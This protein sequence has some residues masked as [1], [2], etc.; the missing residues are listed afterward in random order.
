MPG[1]FKLTDMYR[2]INNME[3][4]SLNKITE[5]CL[6]LDIRTQMQSLRP[7]N[8]Y[9]F[10]REQAKRKRIGINAM[11]SDYSNK[12]RT[13]MYIGIFADAFLGPLLCCTCINYFILLI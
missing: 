6:H 12:R 8:A 11:I 4:G 7:E 2:I 5:S 1:D 9:E 10:S 3:E 13:Y